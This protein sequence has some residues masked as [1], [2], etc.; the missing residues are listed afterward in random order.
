MQPFMELTI[1]KTAEEGL[2][3]LYKQ[4]FDLILMDIQLPGMN[5]FEALTKIQTH[6]QTQNIPVIAVTA[7]AMV[8]DVE[9]GKAAGFVDYIS[10]PL[11]IPDFL[12]VVSKTLND[13]R[14]SRQR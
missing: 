12:E 7:N 3:T 6:Q 11:N 2:T 5:G 1:E 8:Q 13:E 9:M 10:K 4:Q 14:Y